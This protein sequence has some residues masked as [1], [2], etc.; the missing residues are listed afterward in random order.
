MP[1]SLVASPLLATLNRPMLVKVEFVT[2]SPFHDVALGT[3]APPTLPLMPDSLMFW[4][5][6]LST[7]RPPLMAWPWMPSMPLR[8][9]IA[10]D[11]SVDAEIF[12]MIIFLS[13]IRP[14]VVF[15]LIASAPCM[16][17]RVPPDPAVVPV[18]VIVKVPAPVLLRMIALLVPE[19]LALW[20]ML[21]KITP[22]PPMV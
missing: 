17:W 1:A 7:V 16:F 9:L 21:W 12:W 4:K 15:R 10:S 8:V 13:V 20:L 5:V 2:V 18:P 3:P 11:A 22:L 14:P 19:L 6:V